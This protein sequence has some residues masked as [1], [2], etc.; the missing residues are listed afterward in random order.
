MIKKYMCADKY[1][2]NFQW[3]LSKEGFK[4]YVF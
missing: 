4:K 2:C 3:Y 1:E